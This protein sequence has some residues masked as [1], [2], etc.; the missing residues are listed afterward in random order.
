[1]LIRWCPFIPELP[2][3]DRF[4]IRVS[5]S[6]TRTRTRTHARTHTP[7]CFPLVHH[8]QH[9]WQ[10]SRWCFPQYAG[11]FGT[12]PLVPVEAQAG[13]GPSC[14]WT[15][16]AWYVQQWLD[17]IQSQFVHRHL[18]NECSELLRLM[19]E[20]DYGNLIPEMKKIGG[21]HTHF[22]DKLVIVAI[23]GSIYMFHILAFLVILWASAKKLAF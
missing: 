19:K 2:L 21:H 5:G 22:R 13:H 1:M 17:A 14:S 6:I 15:A 10:W 18:E 7:G 11:M 3:Q 8:H 23:L 4:G 20:L 12:D 16:Q 9:K